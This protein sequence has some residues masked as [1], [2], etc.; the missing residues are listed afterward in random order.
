MALVKNHSLTGQGV[1]RA[2]PGGKKANVR[3][4]NNAV[5]VLIM[6]ILLMH[7][8]APGKTFV[9]FSPI[10]CS[11]NFYVKIKCLWQSKVHMN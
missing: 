2:M 11:L 6:I 5:I 9:I 4:Y 1:Y 8:E 10:L 3:F 7:P